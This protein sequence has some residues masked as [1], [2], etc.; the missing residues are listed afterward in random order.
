MKVYILTETY[1][2]SVFKV[3]DTEDKAEAYLIEHN[4]VL[5]YDVAEWEVE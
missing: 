2:G 1:E 3:F 5:S 4:L